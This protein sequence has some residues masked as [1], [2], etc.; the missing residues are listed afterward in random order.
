MMSVMKHA[1]ANEMCW[2]T[3]F[4]ILPCKYGK[5]VK[6]AV[7]CPAGSLGCSSTPLSIR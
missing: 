7:A 4:T 5:T 6:L 2:K 1:C 3:E